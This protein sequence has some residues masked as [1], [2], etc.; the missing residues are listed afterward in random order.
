MKEKTSQVVMLLTLVV[1][2]RLE[3]VAGS[4]PL[5]NGWLDLNSNEGLYGDDSKEKDELIGG[6]NVLKGQ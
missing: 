6:N 2:G 5:M 1:V 3:R 4:Y